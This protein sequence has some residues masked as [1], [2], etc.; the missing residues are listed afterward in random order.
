MPA[1]SWQQRA[2]DGHSLGAGGD[3]GSVIPHPH[4]TSVSNT[5]GAQ[6]FTHGSLAH[7]S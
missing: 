2:E 7:S 5:G 3:V 1:V 4:T 6:Q